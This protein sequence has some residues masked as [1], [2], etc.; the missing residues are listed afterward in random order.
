MKKRTSTAFL[1]LAVSMLILLALVPHHHHGGVLCTVME[2]CN[3]NHT[4][5]DRHTSHAGDTTKCAGDTGYVNLKQYD[6]ASQGMPLLLL[7]LPF[8]SV[9]TGLLFAPQTT[10]R[11]FREPPYPFK[12]APLSRRNALRAPPVLS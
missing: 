6:N 3:E 2:Y 7:L 4:Y 8:L 11:T 12:S 9:C 1:S 5:N 10:F